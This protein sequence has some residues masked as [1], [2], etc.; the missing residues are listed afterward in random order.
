[1]IV[2]LRGSNDPTTIDNSAQ[3]HKTKNVMSSNNKRTKKVDNRS[4]DHDDSDED[5]DVK[6]DDVR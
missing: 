5:D 4:Y 6:G 2:Q 1:M 3:L